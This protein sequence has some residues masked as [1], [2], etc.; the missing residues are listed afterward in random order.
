MS[1]RVCIVLS[2]CPSV[3][4]WY[5]VL[6][7]SWV[8][9]A[10]CNFCQNLDV[11]WVPLSDTMDTGTPCS[12]TMCLMYNYA[13][14]ATELVVLTGR[15]YADFVN[16]STITHMESYPLCVLGN[17]TIK[18]IAIRSHFHSGNGIS[19]NNPVD[20]WCSIFT[21]WQV[22]HEAT[23]LATSFFNPLHQ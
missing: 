18:S 11:N 4:G 3:C 16:L 13:Y 7:S 12:D 22:R 1:S 8:P 21:Y 23:N 14:C 6:K 9:I 10:S 15:K 19:Y 17:P 5:A 20:F 2:V